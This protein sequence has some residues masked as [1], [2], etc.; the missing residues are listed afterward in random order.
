[1]ENGN[2]WV[3]CVEFLFVPFPFLSIIP[4]STVKASVRMAKNFSKVVSANKFP[5]VFSPN[6]IKKH[7]R[8][9]LT[10]F[11]GMNEERKC[12]LIKRIITRNKLRTIEILSKTYISASDFSR[13]PQ[14]ISYGII[15]KRIKR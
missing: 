4:M 15:F 2:Y 11:M 13:P 9:K 3:G 8:K 10:T 14:V 6:R 12:P 1:V 5:I 7:Q